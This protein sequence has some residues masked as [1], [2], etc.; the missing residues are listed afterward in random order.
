MSDKM[1]DDNTSN[2]FKK[3]EL[4]K[5][6]FSS[7]FEELIKDE[8][9]GPFNS[10]FVRA[11]HDPIPGEGILAKITTA[12]SFILRWEYLALQ[13]TDKKDNCK[14]LIGAQKFF[15]DFAYNTIIHD[16]AINKDYMDEYYVNKGWA[17]R[18]HVA[19]EDIERNC[20]ALQ[21]VADYLNQ[22]FLG[23]IGYLG[24]DKHV[25]IRFL[26]KVA[27]DALSDVYPSCNGFHETFLELNEKYV[28]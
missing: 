11:I 27:C 14:S 18:G 3:D 15:V 1:P 26:S 17:E 2:D 23:V 9:V 16:V 10:A 7:A 6:F 20:M 5:C 4:L 25:Y 28:L 8:N 19:D 24:E 22:S 13:N 21:K 12:T